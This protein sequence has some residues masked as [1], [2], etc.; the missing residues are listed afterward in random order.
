[1]IATPGWLKWPSSAV[2]RARFRAAVAVR[3]RRH[4]GGCRG[5]VDR[6]V[7][8]GVGRAVRLDE[9]DVAVRAGGRDHVE[10][11]A[12][13]EPP[14]VV[15]GRQRRRG[16]VLVDLLE[17]A[18]G[19]RCTPAVRSAGGRPRDPSRRS[20]RRRR[21]RWRPS[22]R[23]TPR[24]PACRPTGCRP[25]PYP[26]GAVVVIG[27]STPLACRTAT[28]SP[29]H[30]ATVVLR[31]C[32]QANGAMTVRTAFVAFDAALAEAACGAASAVVIAAAPASRA[33]PRRDRELADAIR[34]LLRTC[35]VERGNESLVY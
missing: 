17:A 19:R 28:S 21:R 16:A 20:G 4:A 22:C 6:L 15:D 25:G 34:A 24:R 23:R 12:D 30:D 27:L 33:R 9:Q 31:A 7:Q 1:M 32:R 8:V 14:A 18:V 26:L 10:V 35:A 5:G 3:D 29:K 2:W 13:L 11:E